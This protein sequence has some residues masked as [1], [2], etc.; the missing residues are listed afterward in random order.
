MAE[1]RVSIQTPGDAAVASLAAR[2]MAKIAGLNPVRTGAIATATSE[3]ATNILKYA[4]RG[5]I[6]LRVLSS[7]RAGVEVIAED[8]GPGI[9]DLELAMADHVS[10]GGTLGLGL[11]GA[12]RLVDEFSVGVAEPQGARVRL[13]K[14]K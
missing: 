8:R 12:K 7:P 9:A 6:T 11:P 10:S 14:W 2:D 4:G 3:L 13:V 5:W 1:R